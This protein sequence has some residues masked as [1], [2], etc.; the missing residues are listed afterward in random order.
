MLGWPKLLEYLLQCLLERG[1]WVTCAQCPLDRL[2]LMACCDV[3]NSHVGMQHPWAQHTPWRHWEA[4]LEQ[5]RQN[6][7]F[8]SSQVH[9]CRHICGQQMDISQ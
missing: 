6:R 4:S 8:A 5:T 3:E 9:V 7:P 1:R 2:W